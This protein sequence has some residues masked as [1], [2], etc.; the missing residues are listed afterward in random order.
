M[1]KYFGIIV[2]V[3]LLADILFDFYTLKMERTPSIFITLIITFILFNVYQ[4]HKLSIINIAIACL[5]Y[6]AFYLIAIFS[7]NK[8]LVIIPIVTFLI[9]SLLFV[10]MVIK[11]IELNRMQSIAKIIYLPIVSY[12]VVCV[13]SAIIVS[14]A[15]KEYYYY[16]FLVISL[17]F[18]YRIIK[19]YIMLHNNIKECIIDTSIFVVIL[20]IIIIGLVIFSNKERIILILSLD[21]L[22]L[23]PFMYRI[24]KNCNV[25]YNENNPFDFTEDNNIPKIEDDN[26]I[27]AEF[28]EKN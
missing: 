6:T 1:K 23:L 25:V 11:N 28:E 3:I 12:I 24:Y 26:I 13:F 10:I 22:L 21:Y 15:I 18:I 8:L 19:K 16:F 17:Y 2:N 14:D 7:L 4:N 9:T 5:G 27:D 20:T